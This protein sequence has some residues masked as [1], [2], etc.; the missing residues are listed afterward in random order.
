MVTPEPDGKNAD[1]EENRLPSD[2]YQHCDVRRHFIGPIAKVLANGT[3][4]RD[5]NS[6]H[7]QYNQHVAK[8][9]D[10]LKET[11]PGIH[12]SQD[13]KGVVPPRMP[14]VYYRLLLNARCRSSPSR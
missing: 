1:E 11:R 13:A 2:P 14:S 3:G 10:H 12:R 6:R 7:Y 8:D 5:E 4:N 9:S